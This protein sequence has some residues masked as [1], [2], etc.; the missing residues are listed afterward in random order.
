[1]TYSLN[2][3]SQSVSLDDLLRLV[4][5]Y[6]GLETVERSSS[7]DVSDAFLFDSETLDLVVDVEEERVVARRI[8]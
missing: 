4:P 6:N 2:V 1:M 8:V 5:V 3:V 7:H